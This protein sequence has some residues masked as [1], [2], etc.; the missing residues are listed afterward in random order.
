MDQFQD[1]TH[2]GNLA[3][4]P[5]RVDLSV[6]FRWAARL[7]MHEAVAIHFSLAVNDFGTKFLMNP[8][9]MYFS[10]IKVSDMLLLDANDNNTANF[11]NR[12]VVD[13]EFGGLAFGDE[14]KR[15]AMAQSDPMK[16]VMIMGNHG[17]QILG[18]DVADTFNWL[19]YFELA[20]VTYIR[21]M[22]T[23]LP[24]HIMSDEIA[25]KTAQ[26]LD[27]YPGQAKRHLAELMAMLD[28]E[29]SDY[30]H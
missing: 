13:A 17:V 29:S 5:K 28:A 20:A 22:Q 14:G 15:C 16:K 19:H 3:H 21:A 26:E 25:E 1:I 18:A 9:Q 24:L 23:G 11:F 8:N 30:A 2:P 12:Y 7:G 27:G 6:A 10:R 4:W